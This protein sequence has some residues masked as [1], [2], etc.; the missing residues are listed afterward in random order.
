MTQSDFDDF[1]GGGSSQSFQFINEG[2][3]ISGI[4]IEPPEKLQQTD[5]ESGEPKFW[6][7]GKP[8]WYY[9][10]KLQTELRDN[11]EDDG[12]RSL[13][14]S[15]HRLDAVR[16]AVREAK[17]PTLVVGGKLWL[18]FD[19][20]EDRKVAK[21]KA[22]PAKVGWSAKYKAPDREPDFMDE[23]APPATTHSQGMTAGGAFA[24][25]DPAASSDGHAEASMLDQMKAKR[26][27]AAEALA[28]K[29]F[30]HTPKPATEALRE[31]LANRGSQPDEP[32]F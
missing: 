28:K 8:R 20:F 22:N 5:I 27:A 32:P 11:D 30:Y 17:A 2:D 21:Y 9:R 25:G 24:L 6:P 10:I 31:T 13:S 3:S 4:I 14:L 16:A 29:E 26:D 7:N 18:R 19:A 1:M 12:I 15:W 23:P